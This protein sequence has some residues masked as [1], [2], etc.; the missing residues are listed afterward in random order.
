M[1]SALFNPKASDKKTNLT[2]HFSASVSES[3][4]LNTSS[5]WHLLMYDFPVV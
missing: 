4:T 3:I 2:Q 5:Y 1:C